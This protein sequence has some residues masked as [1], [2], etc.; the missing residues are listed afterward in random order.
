VCL[1]WIYWLI[2][3]HWPG[4]TLPSFQRAMFLLNSRP[5]YLPSSLDIMTIKFFTPPYFKPFLL[6]QTS[7]YK[8]EFVIIILTFWLNYKLILNYLLNSRDSNS[9][10]IINQKS[11]FSTAL[12]S[13]L[14]LTYGC[15]QAH[16]LLFVE[17]PP[18]C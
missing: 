9:D 10:L 7:I 11:G 14:A 1:E 4:P 17:N 16:Q 18:C 3:P 6:K 8:G 2:S 13:T 15:S 5:E 12:T